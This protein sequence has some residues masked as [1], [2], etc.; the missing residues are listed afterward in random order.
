M[1][2]RCKHTLATP[3]TAAKLLTGV[4]LLRN[5]LQPSLHPKCACMIVSD[6]EVCLHDSVCACCAEVLQHHCCSLPK[7]RTRAIVRDARQFLKDCFHLFSNAQ[8]KQ[9]KVGGKNHTLCNDRLANITG[10]CIQGWCRPVAGCKERW[11]RHLCLPKLLPQ[12]PA[13]ATPQKKNCMVNYQ[14]HK[15]Q[16]CM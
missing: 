3:P 9:A 10:G 12:M 4:P 15:I 2:G 13:V 8:C 5:C 6:S 1:A 11:V 7:R 16:A 14:Q